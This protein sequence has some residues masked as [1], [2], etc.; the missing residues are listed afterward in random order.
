MVAPPARVPLGSHRSRCPRNR[1][2]PRARFCPG[3]SSRR[4]HPGTHRIPFAFDRKL[5]PTRAIPGSRDIGCPLPCP[6]ASSG[7]QSRSGP[8]GC[9]VDGPASC[10][11]GTG[12]LRAARPI[13]RTLRH[14]TGTAR[15]CGDR[16]ATGALAQA[17][18]PP[19]LGAVPGDPQWRECRQYPD[20]AGAR[21]PA[22]QSQFRRHRGNRAPRFPGQP[23]QSESPGDGP[24]GPR[25]SRCGSP[26]KRRAHSLS[27][28][29][30]AAAQSVLAAICKKQLPPPARPT[31]LLSRCGTSFDAKRGLER[32]RG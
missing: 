1:I 21:R 28:F 15:F 12:R 17:S 2:Q 32:A 30:L 18:R 11:S 3:K 16:A 22:A 5:G 25:A 7:S 6:R 31:N 4:N 26:K 19:G 24:P 23:C 14:S 9:R 29:D 13:S 10:K 8:L 27:G 20:A